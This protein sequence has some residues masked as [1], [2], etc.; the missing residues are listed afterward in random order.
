MIL[1]VGDKR[2]NLVG[3]WYGIV[4]LVYFKP[5]ITE[6]IHVLDFTFNLLRISLSI[7]FIFLYF[8]KYKKINSTWLLILL[9]FLTTMTMTVI[10]HGSYSKTISH[11]IPGLGLLAFTGMVKNKMKLFINS[12]IF[13]GTFLI[14]VNF[15]SFLMFPNG[16]LFRESAGTWVWILGQKQDVCMVIFPV[17]LLTILRSYV[18]NDKKLKLFKYMF[19]LSLLTTLLEGS[20]GVVICLSILG[21]LLILDKRINIKINKNVLISLVVII[22]ALIQY[23]SY[24][25]DKQVALQTFLNSLQTGGVK[26]KLFTVSTRFSMWSFA[27]N[28]FLKYPLTGVGDL[29]IDMW[30]QLSGFTWYHSIMDNLYM[31]IILNSGIIGIILFLTIVNNNFKIIS[32]QWN[33][34]YCRML[35]Y[36]LFSLCILFLESSPFGAWIIFQLC[37][38][39]WLPYISNSVRG[40][41][42]N[43]K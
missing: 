26:N 22:F 27:W 39:L 10:F 18:Y 42:G 20:L 1:K 4:A 2:Y 36:L 33:V 19:V 40:T 34:V 7:A 43:E 8:L 32:E 17:I 25:F 15:I 29:S 14:I 41:N 24:T 16:I 23:I 28:I 35:G 9:L 38:P 11:Y 13:V 5:G 3:I 21:F 37:A 6:D 30:K 31:D 12:S